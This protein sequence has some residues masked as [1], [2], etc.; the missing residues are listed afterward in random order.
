MVAVLLFVVLH[1]VVKYA[2]FIIS[3]A[4]GND[5][6][7]LRLTGAAIFVANVNLVSQTSVIFG[8]L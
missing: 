1:A 5:L 7:S 6:F 3:R 2:Y 4:R 8:T